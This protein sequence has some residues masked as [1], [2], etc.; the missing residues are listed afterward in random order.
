[1][2]QPTI[3][4]P[5]RIAFLTVND[6]HDRR[7]WSGT[8]YAMARALEKHCGTLFYVGPLKT[9]S[10]KI[11]RK[12]S[13]GLK[14]IT[15]RTFM[16][17]QTIWFSRELGKLAGDKIRESGCNVIFAPAQSSAVAH[18]E[19]NLP[20]VYLSDATFRLMVYYNDE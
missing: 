5:L 16:F 14:K 1:M 11:R 3:T 6:P 12:F 4:T 20:I 9:L 18:L 15:G 7:S 2:T 13:V 8:E 19:T 17:N 10:R